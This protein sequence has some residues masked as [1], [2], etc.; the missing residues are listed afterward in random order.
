VSLEQD[1]AILV[2]APLL[3]DLGPDQLRLLAFSAEPH[4]LKP[5]QSLFR[6][7]EPARSAFV[8]ASGLMELSLGADPDRRVL[9]RCGA[10]SML[11]ELHLFVE[12][13]RLAMAT[14]VEPSRLLEIGRDSMA[15]ML[16]EY[17]EAAAP[18][19]A[20]IAARLQGTVG[21]LLKVREVLRGLGR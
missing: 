7:G 15:R 17:P 21:D 12:S 3:S 9:E 16:E 11:S 19:H 20:R 5:G 6:H 8:V 13:R 18:L 4:E 2:Q 1:I 14:A 10:G